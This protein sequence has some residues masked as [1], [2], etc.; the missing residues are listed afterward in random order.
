M[1]ELFRRFWL[2][3]MMCDELPAPDCVPVRV[4]VMN[5]DL[6]AFRQ[7]DGKV[8]IIDAYCPHRGAAMFFGRNEHNGLRCIYHGWKFDAEG[9]CVDMPNCPEGD[10]YRNKIHIRHYPN[11]EAG[12]LV[13][14]YMGPADK[15]PP[16]PQFQFNSL[17]D[18]HVYVSK[19]IVE[20]NWVQSLD[21]AWD[22]SHGYFL[23]SAL[24]QGG[25]STDGSRTG[26]PNTANPALTDQSRLQVRRTG[27]PDFSKSYPPEK[28]ETP[29]GA[30]MT[31][32][33][34][35][36]DGRF[37]ARTVPWHLPMFDG[38]GLSAPNVWSSNIRIPIDNKSIF[39]YRYRWSPAPLTEE[40]VWEY[41][42]GGYVYP[43]LI[44]GT[45]RTVANIHNDYLQDRVAQKQFTFSGIKCFPLQD[46][47]MG[48]NQWGPIADRT[49][50]H[51][52]SSDYHIIY[53]RR[54]LIKTAKALAA[55]VDPVEPF[56]PEHFR[57]HNANAVGDTLEEAVQKVH[58]AS[59]EWIV[60]AEPLAPQIA[61]GV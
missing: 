4:K 50:E 17:P 20:C 12:K 58:A 38:F 24:G 49:Q 28:T 19:F 40:M 46:I 23:H 34:E 51:L 7:T 8:G 13:W 22:P 26:L 5:E 36:P 52:C 42:H 47:A 18:S 39:W 3:V 32:V 55:G 61:A 57:N 14:A 43:E 29:N 41:K 53:W 25:D 15:Q 2:P 27:L 16:F 59:E 60:P 1:G 56:Q 54:R 30:M 6:V 37:A 9:E 44:P 35:L 21:G 33:Q 48:E 31:T 10:T 11:V 45:F